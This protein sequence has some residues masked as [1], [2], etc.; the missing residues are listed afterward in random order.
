MRHLCILT[1]LMFVTLNFA[2]PYLEY[3]VLENGVLLAYLSGVF[4]LY[5]FLVYFTIYYLI[6]HYLLQKRYISFI[7]WLSTLI[8]AMLAFE[9]YGEFAILPVSDGSPYLM[10]NLD[11]RPLLALDLIANFFLNLIAF[12][13]VSVTVLL[14]NWLLNNQKATQLEKDHLSNEVE[15]L[16]EQINP[17][18]M[19]QTLHFAGTLEE[20]NPSQASDILM[21]LSRLLRYQLYDCHHTFVSLLSEIRYLENYLLLE[22]AYNPRLSFT[23]TTGGRVNTSLIPPLLFIPLIQYMADTFKTSSDVQKT[24]HIE[25]YGGDETVKL[26]CR[27][28]PEDDKTNHIIPHLPGLEKVTQRLNILYRDQYKMLFYGHDL[29]SVHTVNLQLNTLAL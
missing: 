2:V 8:V 21:R 11:N 7:C 26:T 6:P 17:E 23:I 9:L 27:L 14:K 1:A 22:K 5:I 28:T 10:L 20:T 16:K 3:P 18:F 12:I 25:F 29:Q 15:N 13:G 19:F 4:F 24:L